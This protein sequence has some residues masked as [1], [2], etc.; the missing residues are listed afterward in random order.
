MITRTSRAGKLGREERREREREGGEEKG[1]GRE[2]G[3]REREKRKKKFRQWHVKIVIFIESRSDQ[4]FVII[5]VS[6]NI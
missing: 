1:K 6:M 3:K 4:C 2:G 5:E